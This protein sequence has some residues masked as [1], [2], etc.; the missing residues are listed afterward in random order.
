MN[1]GAMFSLDKRNINKEIKFTSCF[2]YKGCK[3]KTNRKTVINQI[4]EKNIVRF[5]KF[6]CTLAH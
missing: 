1:L 3:N 5:A 6:M 2:D 4:Y